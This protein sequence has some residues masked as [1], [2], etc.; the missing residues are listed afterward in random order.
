MKKWLLS[1]TFDQHAHFPQWIIEIVGSPSTKSSRLV[2]W[3]DKR[4]YFYIYTFSPT[5]LSLMW[6]SLPTLNH[7]SCCSLFFLF[8]TFQLRVDESPCKLVKTKC[9]PRVPRREQKIFV[10]NW[11]E[12]FC[13]HL[14]IFPKSVRE[15]TPI[16]VDLSQL[17]SNVTRW[18]LH[19][20]PVAQLAV[21]VNWL[22]VTLEFVL[23]RLLEI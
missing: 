8:S 16:W 18:S 22:D 15:T 4:V 3:A 7:L 14:S 2:C 10:E 21:S 13:Q 23:I 11:P 12:E 17:N 1:F 5:V 19:T 9:S 6:S 20:L